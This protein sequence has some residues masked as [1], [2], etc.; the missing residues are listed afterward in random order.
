MS[1]IFIPQSFRGY[2][3]ENLFAVIMITTADFLSCLFIHLP[4]KPAL[5][6]LSFLEIL[7]P[8]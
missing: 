6:A 2:F 5:L 4:L 7:G 1:R 8:S 3:C